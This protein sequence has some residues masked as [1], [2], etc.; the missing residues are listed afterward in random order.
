MKYLGIDYGAK[1]IGLAVSIEGIAFPRGVI[2][3]DTS[4]LT[5]LVDIVA[6]EKVSGVVVGDTRSFGGHANPVTKAADAFV[7][8][9]QKELSVPVVRAR[10]AGSSVEAARYAPGGEKHDD[11]AA[12]LILQ[13]YLD[14]HSGTLR[15]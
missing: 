1:R 5:T 4:T 10:E 8:T 3:N 13:G 6:K 2:E 7:D 11:A 15:A 9:L 14:S 12:A